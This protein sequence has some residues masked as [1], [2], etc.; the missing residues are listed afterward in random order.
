MQTGDGYFVTGGAFHVDR[1]VYWDAKEQLIFFYGNYEKFTQHNQLFVV[2]AMSDQNPQCITCDIEVD[3]VRQTV[4]EAQFDKYGKYFVLQINGP[5]VPSVALYAWN[6]ST[7]QIVDIVRMRTLQAN[8]LI[9]ETLK[10]LADEPLIQYL[11][12]PLSVEGLTARVKLMIPKGV[13]LNGDVKLPM[14]VYA[15]AGPNSYTGTDDWSIGWGTYLAVN[16]SVVSAIIDGRGMGR[17]GS[18]YEFAGYRN[19]GTVEVEDQI[20]VVE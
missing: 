13:S 9:H 10:D 11:D 14:L 19:L 20:D 16:K 2:R 7:T 5:S 3:G 6:R 4:Y 18:I 15:Y 12:V 17:R 1:I 8:K